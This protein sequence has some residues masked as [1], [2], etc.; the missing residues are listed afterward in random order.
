M[1]CMS[2]VCGF[3][4]AVVK[5]RGMVFNTLSCSSELKLPGKRTDDKTNSYTD[6]KEIYEAADGL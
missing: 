3:S 6:K 2:N 1:V 5:S 4:E